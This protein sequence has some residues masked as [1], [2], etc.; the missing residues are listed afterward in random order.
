[1]LAITLVMLAIALEVDLMLGIALQAVQAPVVTPMTIQQH[2]QLIAMTV[3]VI[4]T[5]LALRKSDILRCPK[6]VCM[7]NCSNC[8]NPSKK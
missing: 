7:C 2:F 6:I 3:T 5:S 8:N 4:Q 1:M